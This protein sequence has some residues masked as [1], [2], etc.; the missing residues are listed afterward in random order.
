MEAGATWHYRAAVLVWLNGTFGVGKTTT[1]REIVALSSRRRIFDPEWVGYMLRAHLAD[2]EFDDFQELPPWRA[3]V[4]RTAEQIMRLT[5]DELVAVQTVL[6]EDYWRELREG[7]AE[8]QVPL[9]HVVLDCDEDALR[10]R[11]SE[12]EVDAGAAEWRMNHI[13]AYRSAREWM[14]ADADLVIDISDMEPARA[15]ALVDDEV[16]RR[17]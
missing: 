5:D 8:L 12:D 17:T 3:L 10:K 9:L 15:A 2:L 6:V 7:F 11:I 4:P 13:D 14:V 1:A 16:A